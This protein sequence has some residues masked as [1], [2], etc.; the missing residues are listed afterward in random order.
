MTKYERELKKLIEEYLAMDEPLVWPV[1]NTLQTA[2]TLFQENNPL[3]E[4][5]VAIKKRMNAYGNMLTDEQ[6]DVCDWVLDKIKAM[7]GDKDENSI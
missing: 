1:E 6:A 2:L 5:E 7:K 3:D 4:V